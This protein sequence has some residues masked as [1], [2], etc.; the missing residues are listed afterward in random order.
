ME[1]KNSSYPAMNQPPYPTQGQPP[2]PNQGQFGAPIYGPPP[3]TTQR[4]TFNFYYIFLGSKG[5]L[6]GGVLKMCIKIGVRSTPV[7]EF[8]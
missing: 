7:T 2:Y 1:E 4:K 8:Q 3:I 6:A 5:S